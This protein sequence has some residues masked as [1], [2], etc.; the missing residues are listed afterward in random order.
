MVILEAILGDEKN[1]DADNHFDRIADTTE[2]TEKDYIDHL[3]R[4]S[5]LGSDGVTKSDCTLIAMCAL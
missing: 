1:S 3:T 2:L 4:R 5:I